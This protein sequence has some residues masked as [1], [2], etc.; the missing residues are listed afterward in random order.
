MRALFVLSLTLA[1]VGC[2][3]VDSNRTTSLDDQATP[4][5]NTNDPARPATTTTDRTAPAATANTRV[6]TGPATPGDVTPSGEAARRDNTAVNER[7][8]EPATKTPL[9]Q[10]ENEADRNTTAEIRP[11]YQR[12]ARSVVAW[13]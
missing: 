6:G 1:F 12:A 13:P 4:G 9:D 10:G 8:R 7:D 2:G 3:K 5:P 11:A